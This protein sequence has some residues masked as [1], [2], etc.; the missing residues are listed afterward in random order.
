MSPHKLEMC[1]II[2]SHHL[3]IV[4]RHYP[5]ATF[6]CVKDFYSVCDAIVVIRDPHAA[7][8]QSYITVVTRCGW[9]VAAGWLP[10]PLQGMQTG[11]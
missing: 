9:L 4:G 10:R 3:V 6:P 1:C 8:Q 11:T 7:K 5:G 2:H